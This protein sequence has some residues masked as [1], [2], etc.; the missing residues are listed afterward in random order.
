MLRLSAL[1][2]AVCL[3]LAAAPATAGAAKAGTYWDTGKSASEIVVTARGTAIKSFKVACFVTDLGGRTLQAG[4]IYLGPTKRVSISRAGRFSY[5]GNAY[6]RVPA[7]PLG[8]QVKATIRGSF[9]GERVKGSISIV[10]RLEAWECLP[11]SFAGKLTK[12]PK[13]TGGA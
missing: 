11:R 12:V 1:T 7:A 8:T 6:L 2:A 9:T 4:S 10:A 3:S 13:V 5:D